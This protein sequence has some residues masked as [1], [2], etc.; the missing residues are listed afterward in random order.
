MGFLIFC[1]TCNRAVEGVLLAPDAAAYRATS[2]FADDH[3]ERF[4]HYP[5]RVHIHEASTRALRMV[6]ARR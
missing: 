3:V 6:G 1:T 4:D 2:A 5:E